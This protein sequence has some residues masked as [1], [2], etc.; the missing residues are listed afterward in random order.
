MILYK[1]Q[2]TLQKIINLRQTKEIFNQFKILFKNLEAEK[3]EALRNRN[4]GASS[5]SARRDGPAI[6]HQPETAGVSF[7]NNCI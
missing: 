7:C 6:D 1:K 2:L 3:E 4:T 5:S